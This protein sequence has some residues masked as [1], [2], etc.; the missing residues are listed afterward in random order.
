MRQH[1]I[2]V[3]VSAH[4]YRWLLL[5]YPRSFRCEFGNEMTHLF[6]DLADDAAC[7]Q[8]NWGLFTFWTHVLCDVVRSCMEQR[9][10]QFQ[11][12]LTMF[13]SSSPYVRYWLALVACLTLAMFVTPADPVSQWLAAILFMIAFVIWDRWKTRRGIVNTVKVEK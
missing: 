12:S 6:R 8:G 1:N 4:V 5:C 9:F 3:E 11:R 10:Y 7:E 2:S 13:Q